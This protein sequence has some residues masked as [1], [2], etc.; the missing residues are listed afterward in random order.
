MKNLLAALLAFLFVGAGHPFY[1]SVTDIKFNAKEKRVQGFV[2]IFTNDFEVVL[3]K[4]NGSSVD[5][6]NGKDTSA[7]LKTVGN[8]ITSHL[9]IRLNGQSLKYSAIGYENE[10]GATF[11]YIES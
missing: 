6:L 7:I 9:D 11:V 4:P 3:K 1:Q 5:L 8:Y 10:D 2:K